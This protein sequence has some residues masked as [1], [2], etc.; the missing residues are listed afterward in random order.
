[1]EKLLSDPTSIVTWLVLAFLIIKDVYLWIKNKGIPS[2][3]EAI[4]KIEC[5]KEKLDKF[6]A[7]N[8]EIKVCFVKIQTE[9]DKIQ[10]SSEE[11]KN[12]LPKMQYSSDETKIQISKLQSELDDLSE[13]NTTTSNTLKELHQW[14]SVVTEEGVKIWYIRPSLERTLEKLK[15]S[16]DNQ[17]NLSRELVNEFKMLNNEL[18]KK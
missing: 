18:H 10:H 14:H 15:E 3:E 13:I 7:S 12:Y 5:V 17:T 8:D 11:I 1:M 6:Q 4:K 9:L 16:I 2:F